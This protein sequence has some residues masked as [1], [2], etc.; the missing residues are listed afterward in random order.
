LWYR[1]CGSPLP[2]GYSRA[3]TRTT[4]ARVAFE[5]G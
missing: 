4:T 1:V 5:K 3:A 2:T